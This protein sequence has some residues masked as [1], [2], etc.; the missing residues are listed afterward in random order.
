MARHRRRTPPP[1]LVPIGKLDPRP[2][3]RGVRVLTLAGVRGM[4]SC[5]SPKK[6]HVAGV[7][8]ASNTSSRRPSYPACALGH[9]HLGTLRIC[10][11][12]LSFRRGVIR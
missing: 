3:K 10:S 5:V 9:T 7:R 11:T 12:R 6:E 2:T 4:C 1:R 8:T